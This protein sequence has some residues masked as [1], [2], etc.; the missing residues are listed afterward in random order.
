M[1]GQLS[2]VSTQLKF[3][4]I[5]LFILTFVYLSHKCYM[6]ITLLAYILFCIT[7]FP[8]DLLAFV[9][10]LISKLRFQ[11]HSIVRTVSN[12]QLCC[13]FFHYGSLTAYLRKNLSVEIAELFTYQTVNYPIEHWNLNR[14][15]AIS[16]PS[17]VVIHSLYTWLHG[18]GNCYVLNIHSQKYSIV[19]HNFFTFI[20]LFIFLYSMGDDCRFFRSCSRCR[21]ESSV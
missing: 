16:F 10:T 1:F 8:Y 17:Q 11:V 2:F 21:T 20:F 5:S 7:S 18:L 15:S 9:T 6:T 12:C 3:T 13:V 4:C 19:A 14:S